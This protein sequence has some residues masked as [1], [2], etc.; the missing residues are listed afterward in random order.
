[1]SFYTSC[2]LIVKLSSLR[3]APSWTI[4]SVIYVRLVEDVARLSAWWREFM[5]CG[6]GDVVPGCP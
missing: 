2:L 4:G 1:M 5:V 3:R 6:S